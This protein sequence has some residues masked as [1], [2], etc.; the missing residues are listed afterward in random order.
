[1]NS[2]RPSSLPTISV[3][4]PIR[5]EERFIEQTLRYLLSQD[6]PIDKLEIIVV[7]GESSDNTVGLVKR[8]AATDSRIPFPSNSTAYVASAIGMST[9]CFRARRRAAAVVATPSVT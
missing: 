7:D 5:N 2:D 1:M 6:Y 3:I 8:M 9:A 4:L